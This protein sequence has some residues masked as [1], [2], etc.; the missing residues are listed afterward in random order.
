MKKALL[1]LLLAIC[2]LLPSCDSDGG[3]AKGCIIIRFLDPYGE[4]LANDIFIAD[5]S[6]LPE[7]DDLDDAVDIAV[8]D[9]LCDGY[10]L[11]GFDANGDGKADAA[12]LAWL[13]QDGKLVRPKKNILLVPVYGT[14]LGTFA[15]A[16]GITLT[17]EK[18]G[19]VY[20]TD[21]LSVQL[22]GTYTFETIN[23]ESRIYLLHEKSVVNGN[24]TTLTSP[25]YIGSS[26][27]L[28]FSGAEDYITLGTEKYYRK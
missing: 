17:F 28:R 16:G 7:V 21:D 9:S 18:D 12:P 5:F 19:F 14:I 20:S 2:F 1:S 26:S 15:S 13:V 24:T 3:E 27:G 4:K 25:Q 22:I 11:I 10:F 23:G 6:A 8:F